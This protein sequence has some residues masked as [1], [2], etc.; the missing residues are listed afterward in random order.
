M[1][2]TSFAEIFCSW[3][4]LIWRHSIGL[5][6]TTSWG[7]GWRG[8]SQV[9]RCSLWQSPLSF[10][11][12]PPS[13]LPILGCL[14]AQK[15]VSACMKEAT[16]PFAPSQG[17][18]GCSEQAGRKPASEANQREHQG[19]DRA[20]AHGQTRSVCSVCAMASCFLSITGAPSPGRMNSQW[21]LSCL[22]PSPEG[23]G[24]G[25]G[26]QSGSPTPSCSG[27]HKGRMLRHW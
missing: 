25:E 9:E 3:S 14:G 22:L 10:G 1:S 12:P 17:T 16:P 23:E 4:L 19:G 6:S 27:K 18:R 11:T 8:I 15:S 21:V 13:P 2:G 26:E 7:S 5:L 20:G 24:E